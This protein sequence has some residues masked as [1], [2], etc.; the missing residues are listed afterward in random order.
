MRYPR[1]LPESNHL[2]TV[3]GATLQIFATWP[4]VNTGF[5]IWIRLRRGF[6]AGPACRLGHLLGRLVRS[7]P[8][9][10]API[11]SKATFNTLPGRCPS[12]LRRLGLEFPSCQHQGCGVPLPRLILLLTTAGSCDRLP[13]PVLAASHLDPWRCRAERTAPGLPWLMCFSATLGSSMRNRSPIN[14]ILP[15]PLLFPSIRFSR[16]ARI[17]TKPRFRCIYLELPNPTLA[18]VMPGVHVITP[19]GRQPCHL[20]ARRIRAALPASRT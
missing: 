3:R 12:L 4:V 8:R 13:G 10:F 14:R 9:S 17:I 1:S 20:P 2:L 7:Q 11:P 19:C 16:S 6:K 5:F 18:P 15:F